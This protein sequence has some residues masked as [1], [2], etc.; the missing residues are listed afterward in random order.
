MLDLTN[1][2]QITDNNAAMIHALLDEFIRTTD[3][4]AAQLKRAVENRESV[5]VSTFSHRIKG[6]AAIVGASELMKLSGEL[7]Q[8]GRMNNTEQFNALLDRI[9]RCYQQ[10]SEEVSRYN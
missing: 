6:S 1:L 8:A 4:D 5:Q 9:H 2:R 3:D 7:E 10:V